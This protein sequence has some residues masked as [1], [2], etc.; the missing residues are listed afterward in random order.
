MALPKPIPIKLPPGFF[1]NGTEYEA[2]ARWYDGNL[3]R[4]ENGRIKPV[5]GWRR[6]LDDMGAL[7]GVARGGIAWRGTTGYRYAAIGTNEKL[8][9]SGGGAYADATP[10]SFVVGRPDAIEGP[11]YGAGPYGMETYGTQRAD[12][13]VILDAGLWSFDLFGE[14]LYAVATSDGRLVRWQP[15]VGGVAAVVAGA[16]TGNIGVL[17][18]DEAHIVVLG[19][20]NDQRKVQWCSFNA[21]TTWTP[22]ATNTAGS[23]TLKTQGQ[24]KT[25]RLFAGVPIILTDTDAHAFDYLGPPLVYRNRNVGQKC[26][27][28]GS[29]ALA[30]TPDALVW[31]GDGAFF[32][33]NG[34]VTQIPC[35]VQDYVFGDLNRLQRSKIFAGANGHFNEVTWDYPSENSTEND[36]YVTYQ[37]KD[38]LWYFGQRER[39]TWVDRGVFIYPFG[40]DADGVIWEHDYGEYLDDGATRTNI[41][42][43]SGPTEIG[44]GERILYVNNLIPDASNGANIQLRITAKTAPQGTS[45]AYGPFSFVANSEGFTP[46]RLCGRQLTMRIE[47]IVDGDWSVGKF[48]ALAAPGGKR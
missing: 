38:K 28:I 40:V 10:A 46:A 44:D 9:I 41:Y 42:L 34:V 5:G 32:Q 30:S 36:R 23:R 29:N 15:S 16:P 1:R 24:I 26:G 21:P 39:L 18:T 11:G 12:N 4:W 31:M 35:E 47:Q 3:V 14:D 6:V 7:D 48:R 37:Y 20:G 13:A 45:T 27:I 33:Y 8:Y 25:G 22:S 17:V 43:Q 19:A 2:G